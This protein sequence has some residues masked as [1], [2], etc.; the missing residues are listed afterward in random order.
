MAGEPEPLTEGESLLLPA[1]QKVYENRGLYAN[2]FARI[3][4]RSPSVHA[5]GVHKV[6]HKNSWNIF[7]IRVGIVTGQVK[8]EGV[9]R[10]S[11]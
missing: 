8:P 3:E 11:R 9:S 6:P 5:Q 2:R 1:S 10:M 7:I 4:Q